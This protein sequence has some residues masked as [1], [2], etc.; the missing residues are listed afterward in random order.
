MAACS[1]PPPTAAA[2]PAAASASV[3]T[4]PTAGLPLVLPAAVVAGAD[5]QVRLAQADGLLPIDRRVGLL[6][7]ADRRAEAFA[8]AL[9]D[10]RPFAAQGR[11]DREL[12]LWAAAEQAR[13]SLPA[14]RGPLVAVG[15]DARG[16]TLNDL[17]GGLADAMDLLP[18]PWPRWCGPLVVYLDT[19]ERGIPPGGVV[20][21]A[22]PLLQLAPGGDLR[23]RT[24][25]AVA[26]LGLDL[27]SPPAGGWPP[28]LRAGVAEVARARAAGEGPSPRLMRERR[29]AAGTAGIAALF[30]GPEAAPELSGAVVAALLVPARRS[31]FPVLL[32]LLRQGAGPAG[33]L[34]VA[35]G[36]EPSGL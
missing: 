9:R 34:R 16:T 12:A 24:A 28:W 30:A 22:L 27:T 31:R 36:L 7:A 8:L 19:A 35:Y 13:L 23:Q 32:D 1:L 29:E 33:A 5:A 20:R 3:L 2:M 18:V 25:A 4:W 10:P 26:V 17:R 14:V 11:L 15:D 6:L 21:P